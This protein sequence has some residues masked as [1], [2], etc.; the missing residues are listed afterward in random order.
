MPDYKAIFEAVES[1]LFEVGGRN[2][3]REQ[4]LA[5]LEPSKHLEGKHFSDGEC[6]RQLVHIAFYS[7]FSA[8]TVTQKLPAIDAAFP[9]FK[10]VAKFGKRDSDRLSNDKNIIRNKGKI[11]ACIENA[12]AIQAIVT[13]FGSFQ[14]WLSS[15]PCPES[16]EEIIA[17][18]EEFRSRF[19]FLGKRVAFHFMMDLGLPVLKPDRVIERIFKRLGLV[20]NDWR[21]DKLYIALIQEGRKFAAAGGY[22]I[23][24]IDR[25]FVAYGQERSLDMGIT[26][27]IC[28][29]ER[30]SCPQCGANNA[31]KYYKSTSPNQQQIPG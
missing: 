19:S 6:Y 3:P 30:P 23:R 26:R 11:K 12:K 9:D 28:M 2:V 13:Q 22:P 5:S 20:P 24:Y 18:R 1:T 16:D 10:T 27:G 29:K 31:C 17:A 15:L 25:V 4:I 8:N 14:A 7:G 21:D